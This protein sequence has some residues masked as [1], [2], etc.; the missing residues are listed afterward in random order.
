MV[1]DFLDWCKPGAEVGP[2]HFL[3]M[4]WSVHGNKKMVLEI[5]FLVLEIHFL[6]KIWC[7][8][9]I[10]RGSE[11][12]MKLPEGFHEVAGEAWRA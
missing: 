7:W 3:C 9:S 8:K 6:V 5:N 1:H 10:F 11:I 12:L 2:G 4:G